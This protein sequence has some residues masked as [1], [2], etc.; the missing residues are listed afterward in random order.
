M[1]PVKLQENVARITSALLFGRD[2]RYGRDT[3]ESPQASGK[4]RESYKTLLY[5]DTPN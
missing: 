1:L 4:R 5:P 2:T 3:G